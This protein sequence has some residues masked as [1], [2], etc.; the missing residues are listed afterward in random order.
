MRCGSEVSG[1]LQVS[2]ELVTEARERIW[3]THVVGRYSYAMKL[4]LLL[5]VLKKKR[6]LFPGRKEN[7]FEWGLARF[8]YEG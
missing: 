2:R 8:C 6:C 4:A 5:S 7:F 3:L 1:G